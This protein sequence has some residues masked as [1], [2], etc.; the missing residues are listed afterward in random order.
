MK[1]PSILKNNYRYEPNTEKPPGRKREL[2]IIWGDE[3]RW[4]E[5]LRA[6]GPSAQGGGVLSI[7]W[8]LCQR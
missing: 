7:I 6:V 3:K 5:T 4:G 2:K 8:D 1:T